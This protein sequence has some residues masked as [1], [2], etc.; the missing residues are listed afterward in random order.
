[1]SKQL[2][3][4]ALCTLTVFGFA[5]CRIHS[6]LDATGAA[7]VEVKYRVAKNVTLELEKKRFESDSVTVVNASVDEEN[8]AN[9]ELKVDDFTKLPTAKFFSDTTITSTDGENG[10]KILTAK[11]VRKNPQKL[12]DQALEYIGKEF[13]ASITLPGEIVSSNATKTKDNTA[14]WSYDMNEFLGAKET[15]MTVTYKLPAPAAKS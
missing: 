11:I 6:T 10:T 12:A 9:F 5:G 15:S 1:M 8:Y 2:N 4:L 13:E 3:T 7:T 14:T